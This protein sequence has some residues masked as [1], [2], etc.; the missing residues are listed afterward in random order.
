[1]ENVLIA[2]AG[3]YGGLHAILHSAFQLDV[4]VKFHVGPVVDELDDAV[5]AADTVDAPE[6]LYDAHWVPMDVV[7]DEVIAVLQ[8]LSLADAVY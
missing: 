8:V 2:C 6:T 1:M 7:I 4:L 3:E 5:L